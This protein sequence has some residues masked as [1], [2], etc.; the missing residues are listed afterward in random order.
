VVASRRALVDHRPWI[1]G[2]G[3]RRPFALNGVVATVAVVAF[4]LPFGVQQAGQWID[5]AAHTMPRVPHQALDARLWDQTP[6]VVTTTVAWRKMPTQATVDR[7]QHDPA[8][9]RRMHVDDFDQL[10]TSLRAGALDAMWRRYG[11]LALAPARWDRMTPRDWDL[12]PQPLRA[13]AF[14]EMV[15]YWSGH[16]QTG[17]AYDL[18]RGTVTNTMAAILM[19]ESGFLHRALSFN[20]DGSRDIG[21]AQASDWTRAALPRLQRAGTI[22]FA[23]ADEI[24]YYDPWQATRVLV[25]WFGLMLDE[26][27]GDLDAAVRAYNRG[28][29]Q[30]RAGAGDTYLALV[31]DR[32]RR[33]LRDET[34]S[35]TWAFLRAKVR[36]TLD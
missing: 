9:W 19:T 23:P 36:D 2:A 16:Y 27:G 34:G 5:R 21:L 15:R 10:P 14:I 22:D 30:A 26:T 29:P 33:Y 31:V 4:G 13:M 24:G 6:V 12:V 28:A 11:H 3:A 25:V 32:R 20:G 17:A 1:A 8:L 18:P 35:P 7:V